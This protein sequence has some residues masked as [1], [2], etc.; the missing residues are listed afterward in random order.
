VTY[1]K[2]LETVHILICVH[3]FRLAY[4]N[5][6]VLI[7]IHIVTNVVQYS[8]IIMSTVKF[9]SVAVVILVLSILQA[10]INKISKDFR[11]PA[12]ILK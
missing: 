8:S 1:C 5:N 12:A 11:I 6:I 3:G 10:V 4:Y 9:L 7:A 2:M